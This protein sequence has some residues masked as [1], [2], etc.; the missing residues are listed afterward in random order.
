[1]NSSE[2]VEQS[3]NGTNKLELK[4]P[5]ICHHCQLLICP[6]YIEVD[7]PTCDVTKTQEEAYFVFHYCL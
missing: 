2:S 6:S 5:I 7:T 1:M 4:G 3:R